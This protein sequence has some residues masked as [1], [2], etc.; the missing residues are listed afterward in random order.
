MTQV[1]LVRGR[2]LTA[3]KIAGLKTF[4]SG[5]LA[6]QDSYRLVQLAD[7]FQLPSEDV[8]KTEITAAILAGDLEGAVIDE[9]RKS[10]VAKTVKTAR[11]AAIAAE[12]QEKLNSPTVNGVEVVSS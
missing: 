11:F 12:L 7:I 3:L 6:V 5:N 2:I 9:T 1:E 4:L 10:V 8:V